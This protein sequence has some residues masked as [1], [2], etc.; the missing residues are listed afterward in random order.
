MCRPHLAL[1]ILAVLLVGCSRSSLD[2]AQV[3][4][5]RLT[6][7]ALHEE[8]AR[9]DIIRQVSGGQPGTVMIDYRLAENGRGARVARTLCTFDGSGLQAG[10][11]NLLAITTDGK[12][13]SDIKLHILKRWWL[14]PLGVA[15]SEAVPDNRG[16][17]GF[18]LSTS[19]AY[20]LQQ[21]VNGIPVGAVYALLAVAYSLVYGL[22]NRVVLTFGEIAI[23]GAYGVLSGASLALVAGLP[24]PAVSLLAGLVMGLFWSGLVSMIIAQTVVAP[25]SGR[26]GQNMIIATLGVAITIQ[27]A[28]RLTQ[29]ASDK[30]LPAVG[31][32]AI[33]L[34]RSPEG[35]IAT[36]TPMQVFVAVIALMAATAVVLFL[37]R[38]AF[39]RNWRAVADDPVTAALFGVDSRRVLVGTVVLGGMLASIAGWI[40]LVHYGGVGFSNGLA[41]GLKALAAAVL[42][43]IGSV[44]GALLGGLIVGMAETLWSGYFPSSWRDVAILGALIVVLAVRPGGFFGFAEL[45]P[46]RI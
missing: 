24:F 37:H 22:V 14:E 5:C 19:A 43:G 1:L 38:S 21:A 12:P 13:L 6:L 44:G 20:L 36:I 31:G 28:L 16:G 10:R 46:R 39:G 25:L 11:F 33:T 15:A 27:E 42:G 7:P 45:G 18:Q 8:G 41:I 35:F 34:A 26:P 17:G 3:R 9:I 32:A 40:L 4:V 23:F 2:P 30:W 29:G